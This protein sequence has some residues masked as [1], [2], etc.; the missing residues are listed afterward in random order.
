MIAET[1][2]VTPQLGSFRGFGGCLAIVCV[3][4]EV[5]VTRI[6]E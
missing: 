5:C 3:E 1:P 4:L 2:S 6:C